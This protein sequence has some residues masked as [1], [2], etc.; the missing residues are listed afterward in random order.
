M[1]AYLRSVR[2]APKK[3]GLIA[4]MVRGMPVRDAMHALQHTHKKGAR[5]IEQLLK[6]AIANAEHNDKQD[7][8]NLIIKTIIVNQSMGYR[9]GVP[10]ARGRVRPMTKFLSH[11]D[12]T[13]GVA[14]AEDGLRKSKRIAK[15]EGKAAPTASQTAKNTV[16][17]GPSKSKTDK[18]ASSSSASDSPA[19][20]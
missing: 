5:I 17:K 6:S 15:R 7:A 14:G 9:R 3:A 13:L 2:I 12:L 1:K 4:S 20:A 10:M 11:I 19:S 18:K 16:K 8:G